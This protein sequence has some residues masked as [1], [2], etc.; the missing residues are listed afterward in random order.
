[1]A[2]IIPRDRSWELVITRDANPVE[3][4]DEMATKG[5]KA[6]VGFDPSADGGAGKHVVMSVEYDKSM[7]SLDQVAQ[8]VEQIRTCGRCSTL[9]KEKL[10]LDKITVGGPINFRSTQVGVD[11]T[12]NAPPVQSWNSGGGQVPGEAANRQAVKKPDVREMFANTLFDAYFTKP[13]MFFLAS[14]MGDNAM[15]E[16]VMPKNEEEMQQMMGEMIDFW[17]G[18][19]D[20][21]RSPEEAKEYLS[22]IRAGAEQE[23]PARKTTSAR[24]GKRTDSP[25]ILIY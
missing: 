16:R 21:F 20:W 15:L 5:Y 10:S 25:G 8:K 22:V 6:V 4:I 23:R 11:N 9:D 2:E 18:D 19:V 12:N 3:T 14:M 24:R 1:M 13:G 17:A 7:Y